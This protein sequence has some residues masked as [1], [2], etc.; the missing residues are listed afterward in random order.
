VARSHTM[1]PARKAALKKAQM[2]SARKR[3]GKGKGKLAAANRRAD[4]KRKISTKRKVLG[5]SMIA[6]GY[7]MIGYAAYKSGQDK[8]RSRNLG[9]YSVNLKDFSPKDYADRFR[10]R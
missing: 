4:G 8:R 9:G 1:T 5:Y 6:A 10:M 3:R 2:A 7:G